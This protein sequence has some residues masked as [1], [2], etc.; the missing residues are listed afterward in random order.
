MFTIF[1]QAKIKN[2]GVLNQNCITLGMC[3]LKKIGIAK[4]MSFVIHLCV[5]IN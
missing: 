2:V 1:Y 5:Q 3:F 4:K